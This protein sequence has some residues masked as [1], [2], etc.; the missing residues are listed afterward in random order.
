M[1]EKE[2]ATL[3]HNNTWVD[4]VTLESETSQGKIALPFLRPC[5]LTIST[6]RTAVE[7]VFDNESGHTQQKWKFFSKDKA[8]DFEPYLKC[9]GLFFT[10]IVFTK[11]T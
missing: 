1:K 4:Y 8:L 6:D 3:R 10:K 5:A 11:C 2:R 7:W 9:S